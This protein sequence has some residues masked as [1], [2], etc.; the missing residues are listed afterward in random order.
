MAGWLQVT[1]DH[2][3]PLSEISGLTSH[4]FSWIN[5]HFKWVVM[6]HYLP[7]KG[8]HLRGSYPSKSQNN[9]HGLAQSLYSFAGRFLGSLI[10]CFSLTEEAT[11]LFSAF[12]DF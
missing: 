12:A 9:C 10:A 5:S 3:N 4:Y 11:G 6:P 2:L 1:L 7:I 8:R